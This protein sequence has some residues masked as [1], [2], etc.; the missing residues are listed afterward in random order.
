MK[1]RSSLLPAPLALACTLLLA[2][3]LWGC[4]SRRAGHRP[5]TETP[6]TAPA[7]EST[8]ASPAVESIRLGTWNV[9]WLGAPSRR[10]Y[11]AKDVAQKPADL[12][13]MIL[14]SGVDVLALQEITDTTPAPERRNAVLDETLAIVSGGTGSRWEY[15][16]LPM[17]KEDDQHL[18]VA[19]NTSRVT[20]TGD[21]VE[22]P[23]PQGAKL[24]EHT[25]WHRRPYAVP[26][27]TGQG[28]TDFAVIPVHLKADYRGDY[29]AHRTEE[30]R[31][32]LAALPSAHLDPDLV[33][34]GDTNSAT[35]AQPGIQA[36]VAAGWR[37]LNEADMKTFWNGGRMDRIL[38]PAAQ[39]EFAT[40]T[41]TVATEG[42][43]A[44]R[45]LTPEQFKQGWTDHYLV[46]A[47][48]R[49][50]PDDD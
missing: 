20:P 18:A 9:E 31:L 19:W 46:T 37:D 27:R 10:S 7:A 24:G 40:S 49:V 3:F 23:V 42:Y 45:G 26:F 16:L 30:I 17:A 43:L 44:A 6:T 35:T 12:A 13:D 33:I 50:L 22:I 2:T 47:D 41:M 8:T 28:L 5:A 15:V 1:V 32:L 48:M 36:L 34:I 38:V 11:H 14:F 21:P 4:G 39:P 25:L 29:S